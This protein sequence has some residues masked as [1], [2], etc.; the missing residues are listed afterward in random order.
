MRL[1]GYLTLKQYKILSGERREA[2][3]PPG[4]IPKVL[5]LLQADG[6]IEKIRRQG[7]M[8]VWD[9]TERGRSEARISL[10]E[11]NRI[12]RKMERESKL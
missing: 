3:G 8:W 5:T 4:R 10:Q 11:A 6:Y 2:Y 12:E 7:R 9:V 1:L